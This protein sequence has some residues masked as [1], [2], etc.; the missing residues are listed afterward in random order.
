MTDCCL[1]QWSAVRR[2]RVVGMSYLGDE[3]CTVYRL[4]NY[5]SHYGRCRRKKIMSLKLI[6]IPWVRRKK[7]NKVTMPFRDNASTDRMTL[8]R[9]DN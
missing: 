6:A 2:R 3:K 8:G 9:K 5:M 7:K 1:A 4:R